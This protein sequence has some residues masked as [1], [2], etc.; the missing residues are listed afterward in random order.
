MR[1]LF[2]FI[3]VLGSAVLIH[4]LAHL[5]AAVLGGVKIKE[6]GL[7]LPPRLMKLRRFRDTELTLNWIPLGGFV[8]PLG[9]FQ[10]DEP[11]GFAAS[12]ARTRVSILLAGSFGNLLAGFLILALAFML[13]GPKSD[14]VRILEVF[15]NSPAEEAGLQAGDLIYLADG[16]PVGDSSK[17]RRTIL[18]QVGSPVTLGIQR[19]EEVLEIS[20]IPLGDRSEDQGAAGFSS[21]GAIVRYPLG[22][23]ATEAMNQIVLQIRETGNALV[24]LATGGTTEEIARVAGPVGLKQASDWALENSIEWD[25]LY[26]ILYLSSI[27]NVG[28]GFTNLLPLPALDGGRILFIL[29]ESMRGKPVSVRLEKIVHAGG[30][31]LLLAL[32]VAL[33]VKDILDP[34]F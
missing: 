16:A 1:N 31:F 22:E 30:F 7:G 2:I 18:D 12:P 13:G 4:E 11:G 28:L 15:P 9:E 26:P 34:L 8:R 24:G 29:M 27:I 3:L 5:L 19:G 20:L 10:A 17:L 32:M 33:S 14:M 21:I 23:A 25:S 6:I